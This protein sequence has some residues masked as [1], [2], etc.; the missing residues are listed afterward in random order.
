M[1]YNVQNVSVSQYL[2]IT[3]KYS[4]CLKSGVHNQ[5]KCE[6]LWSIWCYSLLTGLPPQV[7]PLSPSSFQPWN[8]FLCNPNPSWS[9]FCFLSDQKNEGQTSYSSKR[10]YY[11]LLPSLCSNNTVVLNSS[12]VQ[13]KEHAHNGSCYALE[14]PFSHSYSYWATKTWLDSHFPCLS[15]RHHLPAWVASPM[16]PYKVSIW[17]HFI[18][19]LSAQP[20]SKEHGLWIQTTKLEYWLLHLLVIWQA[21]QP[22]PKMGP[23]SIMVQCMETKIRLPKFKSAVLLLAEQPWAN[24]SMSKCLVSSYEKQRS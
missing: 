2:G 19:M 11:S 23:W 7:I 4:A 12:L 13:S 9:H 16:L 17:G 15:W 8:G 10:V 1:Y 22:Q 14:P 20:R 3:Y 6:T 24:H 21:T 18:P 5:K